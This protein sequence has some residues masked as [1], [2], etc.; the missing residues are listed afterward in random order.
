ME[1]VE[2]KASNI[3]G[4]GV[5]AQQG[6][7]TGDVVLWIDDSRVVDAEH[8]L[9]DADD[10]RHCD[11]LEAGKVVLMGVPERYI[12]HSCDPNTFV[13]TQNGR[14]AVLALRDIAPGEE[15]TYDHCINGSGATVWTCHCGARSCRQEIHSD[16][17]HLLVELQRK[18]LPLLDDW[19]C[20]ERSADVLRLERG[21]V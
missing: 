16:F 12:N 17:F 20:R 10:P 18:H 6:Y 2:A 15:I 11:Y 19:F 13:K 9:G 14:R 7:R 1:G 3:S 21:I 8:P 5:I 4:T